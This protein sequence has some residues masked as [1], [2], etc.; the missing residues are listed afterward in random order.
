MHEK[1]LYKN[2][3]YKSEFGQAHCIEWFKSINTKF[4]LPFLNNPT[5]FY[6]F[7]KVCTIFWDLNK[8][9]KD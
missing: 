9:E 2:L 7:L 3:L 8:L 6:K 5:S 1:I 4:T